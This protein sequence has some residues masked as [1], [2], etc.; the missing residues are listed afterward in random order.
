VRTHHTDLSYYIELTIGSRKKWPSISIVG[1][2]VK[3]HGKRII[4]AVLN[5]TILHKPIEVTAVTRKSRV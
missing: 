3:I 4:S 1:L 5:Y 2:L